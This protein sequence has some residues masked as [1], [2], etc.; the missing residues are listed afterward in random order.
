MRGFLLSLFV[1]LAFGSAA[2]AADKPRLL[3]LTDMGA[4]PDDQQSLVR[5][6]LYANEFEIE[7]LLASSAG[8]T[9]KKIDQATHPEL[10]RELVNAYGQVRPNLIL[11]ASDYPTADWLLARVK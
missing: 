9:G 7:G 1:A 10:I 3:I 11:H 8:T 6:L 4:D 2:P 5:L